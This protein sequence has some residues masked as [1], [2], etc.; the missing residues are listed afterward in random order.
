MPVEDAGGTVQGVG[1]GG[2]GGMGGEVEGAAQTP[3]QHTHLFSSSLE[4]SALRALLEG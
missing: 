3:M 1:R 4:C 2:V